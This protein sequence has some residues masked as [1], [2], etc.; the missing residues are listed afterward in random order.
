LAK[1]GRGTYCKVSAKKYL[2]KLITKYCKCL[3]AN[4]VAEECAEVSG[5]CTLEHYCRFLT[6]SSLFSLPAFLLIY[7]CR[8][9]SL[10]SHVMHIRNK[11]CSHISNA[12]HLSL[13]EEGGWIFF[14][15][16]AV[17]Q[18]LQRCE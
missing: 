11:I 16:K 12:Q 18:S 2:R 4:V 13:G 5:D 14:Q 15:Q 3:S 1:E 6:P 8:L 7:F 17:V 10:A 9:S